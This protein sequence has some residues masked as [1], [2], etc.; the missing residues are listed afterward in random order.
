VINNNAILEISKKNLIS[1]Y[2]FFNNL[3]NFSIAGATIKSDG[4]GL[5]ADYIFKLLLKNGC[6]NFF[7][8]TTG[9]GIRLRRKY[10]KGTI[11]V[12]NGAENNSYKIYKKYNLIPILSN[13]EDY[14]KFK[15][16][17]LYFGIQ[18][19]TGINR[20]G[21][22]FEDY[23]KISFENKFLNIVISHLASADEINNKY[24]LKQL[25]QFKKI[26]NHCKNNK[27]IFSLSNSFGSV[28]SKKY[29]FDMI[30]PGISIYGGHSNNI[31]LKKKIKPVIKLKAKILQV[32]KINENEYV[33]YNQTFK[34]KNKTCIAIIGIGYGDGIKRILSNN[35]QVY[36]NNK[37]F[38]IIGRVSM[39]SIIVDIKNN[40]AM[41]KNETYVDIINEKYGIDNF[42][43][44][45]KTI[46][47]EILTSI[48]KRVERKFV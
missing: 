7:V 11:Y 4:Y 15:N 34:T 45:C 32:K 9:E 47:H 22:N 23:Q 44:T 21:I 36:L 42:A 10:N 19:N 39:D 30:R 43:N 40:Y 6:T 33:G 35:G 13:L 20:L 25:T 41:F 17:S 37:K 16:K 14:F 8:A 2:N 3:D 29:L 27:I 48:S 18:I 24:N 5:G 26:K 12:L 28:L 38:N 46:S 31:K 1:N